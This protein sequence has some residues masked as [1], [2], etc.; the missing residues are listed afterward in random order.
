[1]KLTVVCGVK[2]GDGKTCARKLD[3]IDLPGFPGP[4]SYRD[5][6]YE[7]LRWEERH[8]D[9]PNPGAVQIHEED[10]LHRA[11]LDPRRS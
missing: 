3:K 11:L 4:G 6:N 9:C 7:R 2:D 10:L 8:H 5:G 1:V